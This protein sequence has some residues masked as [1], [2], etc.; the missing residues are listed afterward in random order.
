MNRRAVLGSWRVRRGQGAPIGRGSFS[1][2]GTAVTEISSSVPGE[3]AEKLAVVPEC[4]S[5]P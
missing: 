4:G 3:G 2:L 5:V 1:R